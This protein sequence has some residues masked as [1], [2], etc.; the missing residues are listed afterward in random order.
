MKKEK[1]RN[2]FL[3]EN[4]AALLMMFLSLMNER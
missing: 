1:D 2:M 4:I 3:E